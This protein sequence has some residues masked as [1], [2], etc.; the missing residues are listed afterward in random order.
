MHTMPKT[1]TMFRH[2]QSEENA[3]FFD[4]EAYPEVVRKRVLAVPTWERRLTKKGVQQAKALSLYLRMWHE[5]LAHIDNVGIICG[6]TSTYARAIETAAYA[7]DDL[8]IS[9]KLEGR[10]VERNWGEL[11]D[12]TVEE[13]DR[14]FGD[15]VR[16][17]E[18]E[19]LLW[20]PP[21]GETMQD[22]IMR[23][24]S[25][26]QTLARD[27]ENDHVWLSEHG[28]MMHASM[29]LLDECGPEDLRSMFETSD[30]R[31]ELFNCRVVQ[32]TRYDRAKELRERYVM[33]RFVDPMNP[34]NPET[35]SGWLDITPRSYRKDDLLALISAFPRHLS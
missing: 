31:F 17:R 5:A 22:A 18:R 2:G 7:S 8:P 24:H 30:K 12:L 11:Q 19:A 29:Y 16:N 13:R 23:C 25:L 20:R 28:E 34:E 33:K 6:Y 4:R 21:G 15:I 26:F 10:I 3:V 35:N 14:K 1:L 32:Y 27:H 9:W